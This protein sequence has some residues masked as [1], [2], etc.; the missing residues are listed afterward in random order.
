MVPARDVLREL[1]YDAHFTVR[2]ARVAGSAF[3]C[4][5]VCSGPGRS[6]DR[7]VRPCAGQAHPHVSGLERLKDDAG[8]I[9]VYG[10]VIDSPAQ[11]RGESGAV[12]R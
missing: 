2:S 3:T 12:A 9:T 4:W 6:R 7:G 1:S 10:V 11:S 5:R 8:R